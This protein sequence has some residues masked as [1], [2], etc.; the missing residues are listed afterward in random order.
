ME[1]LLIVFIGLLAIFYYI[2]NL[3]G[4]GFED[5][6]TYESHTSNE[7]INSEELFGYFYLDEDEEEEEYD[8][9][10]NFGWNQGMDYD[11]GFDMQTQQIQEENRLFME[12]SQRFALD[13]V[14]EGL[15]SVT[16][17]EM[18]GDDMTQGN[19]WNYEESY[20]DDFQSSYDNDY[21]CSNDYDYSYSNDYNYGYSNDYDYDYGFNDSCSFDNSFGGFNDFGGMF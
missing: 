3:I 5:N 19:S 20:H 9:E 21:S 4:E 17:Y 14:Q 15:D 2:L 10:D 8:M 11:D 6:L 13:S 12:E 7:S 16:P 18:G 1:S